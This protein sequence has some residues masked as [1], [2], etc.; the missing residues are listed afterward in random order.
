MVRQD[1][2]RVQKG[3]LVKVVWRDACE[4]TIP[5]SVQDAL[6]TR[7]PL[8]GATSVT[9]TT[10][11]RYLRAFNGYIVLDDVLHEECAG[12]LVFRKEAEGKW[13]SIPLGIVLQVVPLGE[14]TFPI[15]TEIKRRRT[16]LKQLRYIPRAKLLS[17]GEV[18]RMLY[19]A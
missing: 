10:I 15:A 5:Q 4:G 11:G 18:T 7:V 8:H 2:S 14:I 16:I 19:L 1:L 12:S 6:E 13:I 9:M 17:S 3:D